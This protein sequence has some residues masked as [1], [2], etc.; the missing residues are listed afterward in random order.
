TCMN[1][2]QKPNAAIVGVGPG[3]GAAIARNFAAAGYAVALL[4]RSTRFTKLLAKELPN[5][6]AIVCDVSDSASINQAFDS[7]EA[8]MGPIHT[9]VFNAGSGIWG[10]IEET[11]AEAFETSWRINALGLFNCSQRVMGAMKA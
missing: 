3:N 10:S 2:T 4:A 7:I 6:Q 9:L 1:H 8:E 11:D 5:A